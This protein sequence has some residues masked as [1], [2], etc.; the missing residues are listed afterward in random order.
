ML[1]DMFTVFGGDGE[2]Q[3]VPKDDDGDEQ[4][5]NSQQPPDTGSD[6]GQNSGQDDNQ[7]DGDS[8]DESSND[9]S[10]AELDRLKRANIALKGKVTKLETAQS[11]AKGDRDAAIERDELKSENEKLKSVVNT[12]FLEWAIQTN[13]KYDWVDT[14]DVVKALDREAINVDLETGEIDGLDLE[15]KRI[16][17]KKPHWLKKDEDQDQQQAPPRSG[18]HPFGG[19]VKQDEAEKK[20]LGEK[21]K[22]PGFGSQAVKF[23]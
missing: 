15:L 10:E 19:T 23:M 2:R 21:F 13:A 14:E 5:D 20:R 17:K 6:D 4:K 16:A 1:S 7:D 22:I 12:K 8:G 18:G 3:E 11:K 9:D